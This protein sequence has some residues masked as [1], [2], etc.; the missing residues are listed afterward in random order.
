MKNYLS[1][2]EN[3][4]IKNYI[5]KIRK[6]NP[7]G[8]VISLIILVF[9]LSLYFTIPTFYNYEKLEREIQ[10]KVSKDF[11]LSLKNISKITY[12]MLPAPHLL[13]EECDIYNKYYVCEE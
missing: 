7:F 13:I 9:L 8:A 3:I 2:L 1:K 4:N 12:L 6:K 10:R 5:S 11:K